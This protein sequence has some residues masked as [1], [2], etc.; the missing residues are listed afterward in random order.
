M[1]ADSTESKPKQHAGP[2]EMPS[3]SWIGKEAPS[4][5]IGIIASLT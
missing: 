4:S 1:T 5:E 3:I 2:I